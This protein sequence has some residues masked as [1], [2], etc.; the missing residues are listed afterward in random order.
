M[1]SSASFASFD[2][3]AEATGVDGGKESEAVVEAPDG[4]K[5]AAAAM[6]AARTARTKGSSKG[7]SDDH[8]ITQQEGMREDLVVSV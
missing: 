8:R 2:A 5:E 7:T 3:E 6:I 4:A 1:G